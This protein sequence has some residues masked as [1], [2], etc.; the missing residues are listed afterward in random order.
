M[1][2]KLQPDGQQTDMLEI[3]LVSV[4]IPTWN[5]EV[6]LLQAIYSALNQT[7]R[8]LE[9]LV[10]DDG[11]TDRSQ[12]IVSGIVDPRVRWIGG[13]HAGLPAV[14]RNRGLQEA[15]G[16]WVA[17]MDSDDVWL[18]NKLERQFERLQIAN[19]RARGSCGNA[20]RYATEQGVSNKELLLDRNVKDAQIDLF[21]LL[22][23]NQVIT[24]TVLLHRSLL[25]LI[26]SF[27]VE[28]GL[29]VGEDYAYWLRVA[30]ITPLVFHGEPLAKYCDNPAS[31]VRASRRNENM[32]KLRIYRNYF[33]W[34]AK[35]KPI[36]IIWILPV[37]IFL[38]GKNTV[39]R[40]WWRC[41]ARVGLVKRK[42]T[43]TFK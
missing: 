1:S 30:S 3:G 43:N 10:C 32:V 2:D 15:K 11:S 41:R 13:R 28:P 16:E 24:S 29:K 36:Q 26:G 19:G 34:L 9:V 12:E 35:Y 18:E 40:H 6:E 5:R 17:F 33:S 37:S 38:S 39:Q 20:L 25:P 21:T 8:N 23:S 14:P 4:I 31:S 7:Y 42:F 22:Q 27:P